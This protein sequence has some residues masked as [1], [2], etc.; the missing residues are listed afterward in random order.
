[1]SLV[2]RPWYPR[3]TPSTYAVLASPQVASRPSP[4]SQTSPP[5]GD[6]PAQ[7]DAEVERPVSWSEQVE[8]A[9]ERGEL[10]GGPMSTLPG[11]EPVAHVLAMEEETIHEDPPASPRSPG[12]DDSVWEDLARALAAAEEFM[13]E[14]EAPIGPPLNPWQATLLDLVRPHWLK[15]EAGISA[16]VRALIQD[17]GLDYSAAALDRALAWLLLQRRDIQARTTHGSR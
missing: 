6:S 17:H 9:E 14:P 2:P 5:A 11:D 16:N 15:G 1:V 12:H 4:L 10:E 3:A 7:S 13:G 8:A